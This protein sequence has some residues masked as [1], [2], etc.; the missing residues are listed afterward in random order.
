MSDWAKRQTGKM[1]R[2][3]WSNDGNFAEDSEI[4][5]RHYGSAIPM[6]ED[7]PVVFEET[8]R[9][10]PEFGNLPT[11]LGRSDLLIRLE[12][13][14]ITEGLTDYRILG[15]QEDLQ[16]EADETLVRLMKNVLVRDAHGPQPF[17]TETE[18]TLAVS[19]PETW[20][21][22]LRTCSSY[23]SKGV[24]SG[25][26]SEIVL[27][28]SCLSLLVSLLDHFYHGSLTVLLWVY[29]LFCW[30]G[31]VMMHC[32]LR[33]NFRLQ[34]SSP[35]YEDE[36]LDLAAIIAF[37]SV[38][39]ITSFFAGASLLTVALLADKYVVSPSFF[40]RVAEEHFLVLVA[41]AC[42]CSAARHWDAVPLI[43][44]YLVSVIP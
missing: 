26:M 33:N 39:I 40:R 18:D 34:A 4:V 17:T 20:S 13:A 10:V 2:V 42:A 28:F 19:F 27:G 1:F 5:V 11:F 25:T 15:P 43:L 37:G 8:V 14:C 32:A 30:R 36:A 35:L 22:C 31:T 24:G 29:C 44:A 38:A 6:N 21:W 23:V 9:G 7:P 3:L 16:E 41:S 12:E